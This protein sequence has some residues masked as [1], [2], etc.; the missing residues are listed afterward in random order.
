M[1]QVVNQH[2]MLSQGGSYKNLDLACKEIGLQP[3]CLF[4][5]GSPGSGKTYLSRK[6]LYQYESAHLISGNA[7][8]SVYN[9]TKFIS[10]HLG[11]SL[12]SHSEEHINRGTQLI[13]SLSNASSEC[14]FIIDDAH[15]MPGSTL[16][17][18]MQL[19]GVQANIRFVLLGDKGLFDKATALSAGDHNFANMEMT[20]LNTKE[21]RAFLLETYK[22]KLNNRKIKQLLL[23]T[24]GNPKAISAY[25]KKKQHL[26]KI[27]FKLYVN[28]LKK[29][30]KD[31]FL[32]TLGALFLALIYFSMQYFIQKPET[33]LNIIVNKQS[34]IQNDDFSPAVCYP[35]LA[36]G[37]TKAQPSTTPLYVVQ[38]LS[39]KKP[40]SIR[41][42]SK[43]MMSAP[44]K[45]VMI[46]NKSSGLYTLF[47]GPFFTKED[48]KE[49]LVKLP[50]SLKSL[51]PWVRPIDQKDLA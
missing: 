8:T 13:N 10:T 2:T 19:V 3:A 35:D 27:N 26:K 17:V 15:L 42:I 32:M 31:I 5:S 16:S 50:D 24:S 40:S 47:Y 21:V 48:A 44:F 9:I 11:L 4:I 38:L 28:Q 6:L 45:P 46:K 36:L 30:T 39:V 14:L 1:E 29:Y 18:I 51:N 12:C 25:I 41:N 20:P 49:A 7:G 22:I 43:A 37:D 34:P 23:E 33:G